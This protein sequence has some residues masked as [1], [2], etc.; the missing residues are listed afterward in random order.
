LAVVTTIIVH[1][2]CI[3]LRIHATQ[4]LA[5]LRGF[6]SVIII[7]GYTFLVKNMSDSLEN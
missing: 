5:A 6:D 2:S 3:F 4:V 1:I 7:R